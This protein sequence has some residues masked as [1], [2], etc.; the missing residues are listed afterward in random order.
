MPSTEQKRYQPITLPKSA[1]FHGFSVLLPTD[2]IALPRDKTI[3]P[4]DNTG[5]LTVKFRLSP[6]TTFSPLD[7]IQLLP[8]KMKL[9]ASTT[10]LPVNAS[11]KSIDAEDLF[12]D[13]VAVSWSKWMA[14]Q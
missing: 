2:N 9:S 8:D 10:H 13:K 14:F 1:A 6:G 5:L 7:T 11:T 12:R 4:S 3:L